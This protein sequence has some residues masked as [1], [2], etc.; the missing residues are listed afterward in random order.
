MSGPRLAAG[1]H[2]T[3]RLT[4]HP[5]ASH[6]E[7]K[8]LGL[9]ALSALVWGLASRFVLWLSHKLVVNARGPSTRPAIMSLFLGP[10]RHTKCHK[11]PIHKSTITA[12]PWKAFLERIPVVARQFV[13]SKYMENL[14]PMGGVPPRSTPRSGRYQRAVRTKVCTWKQTCVPAH[15]LVACARGEFSAKS[16]VKRDT[17][18]VSPSGLSTRDKTRLCLFYL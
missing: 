4:H 5:S 13:L 7:A 2:V 12:K 10:P 17:A 15:S 1:V 8:W 16:K 18:A 6:C 9:V 11:I 3:P 14:G